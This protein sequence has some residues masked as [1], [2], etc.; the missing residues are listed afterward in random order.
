MPKKAP[1]NPPTSDKD[2]EDLAAPAAKVAI[3]IDA[4]ESQLPPK[5]N[6]SNHVVVKVEGLHKSFDLGKQRVHVLKGIDLNFYSGEFVI[7]YGPSGC[8]KSTFLHTVLGLEP[9]D[10]GQVVLRN[11]DLYEMDHDTRTNFRRQKIGMVFQQSNWIKS[12]SVLGNVAYPLWLDGWQEDE[13]KKKAME[14]LGQVEMTDYADY[15]PNELSGGQQQRISLARA[16]V[17]DPWIIM[18]DEPTGNLDSTSGTDVM[19]MLTKLN[20]QDRRM[21]IMVTHD[22][23]FLPLATRRIGMKDGQVIADEH[24]YTR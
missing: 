3:D 12:M 24:D 18:T 1:K 11:E 14:Q 20:R 7:I 16:M 13:A 17:T 9:P 4:I 6:R 10:R 22:V 5:Q 21:I 19:T 23:G 2:P 8:G 15:H